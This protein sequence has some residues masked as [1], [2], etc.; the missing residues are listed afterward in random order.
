MNEVD[1]TLEHSMVGRI[2]LDSKFFYLKVFSIM[3]PID[4]AL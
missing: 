2:V 1:K 4:D 3:Q